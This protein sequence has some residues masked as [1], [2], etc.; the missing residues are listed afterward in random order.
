[1]N[2]PTYPKVTTLNQLAGVLFLVENA[3]EW[4]PEHIQEPE[5]VIIPYYTTVQVIL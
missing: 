5:L 1:V 3:A 4:L 2:N